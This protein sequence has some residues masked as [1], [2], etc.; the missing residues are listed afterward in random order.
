MLLFR[1]RPYWVARYRGAGADLRGVVLVR[2]HLVSANLQGADLRGADL[3]GA[4]LSGA[5]LG[6]ARLQGAD[7]RGAKLHRT[8][9]CPVYLDVQQV[10]L[11][12]A[13]KLKQGTAILRG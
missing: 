10:T 1:L 11:L 6:G 2:A 13:G 7:L 3:G 8:A 9:F 12:H 5:L 4:D